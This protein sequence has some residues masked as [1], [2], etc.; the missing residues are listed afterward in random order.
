M[1]S[2]M[3]RRLAQFVD[4]VEEMDHFRQMLDT[5]EK[6]IMVVWGE[7]GL[8]KTSL[9]F[10]MIH[11]CAERKTRKSEV[12]WSDTRSHTYLD[13]LCKIRD[14]VGVDHFKA[15]SQLVDST[16]NPQLEVK[17]A[18][19]TT[20]EIDV[21]RDMEVT[22]STVGDVAGAMFKNS[23]FVL[24][25]IPMSERA[26]LEN[27]RL[28]NIHDQFVEDLGTALKDEPLVVFFDAVEKMKDDCYKWVWG[29]ML[30][31]AVED[32]LGKISFVLCGRKP[33]DIEPEM[34]MMVKRTELRP[35][36]QEHIAEYLLKRAQEENVQALLNNPALIDFC[37]ET[38]LG[39]T[40]G[41]PLAIA[42][43]I[44][45]ALT[46]FKKG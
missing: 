20:G 15:F 18:V 1:I 44:E 22:N 33:P 21:A 17:L 34:E 12:V 5:R 28:Q 25:G 42:S 11:E 46:K 35:L 45:G 26:E 8:G 24:P 43:S 38:L 29:E 39:A 41:Q 6:P 19:E 2:Y 27:K 40:K 30:R 37:A 9:F 3:E 31:A 14:D 7:A 16:R 13:V 23:T 32:R 10:R 4:R 36:R